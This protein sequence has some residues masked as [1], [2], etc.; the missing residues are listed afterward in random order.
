MVI[1][2]TPKTKELLADSQGWVDVRDVALAMCLHWKKMQLEVKGFPPWP[3]RVIYFDLSTGI[4]SYIDI[5]FFVWQEFG[6]FHTS[7]P[8]NICS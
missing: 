7:E 5:E 8:L 1:A 2:D 4:D 6:M 3:V